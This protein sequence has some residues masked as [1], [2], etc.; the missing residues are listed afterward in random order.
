MARPTTWLRSP[1]TP[2]SERFH[3]Q[4][5]R[6]PGSSPRVKEPGS[7]N[8]GHAVLPCGSVLHGRDAEQAWFTSILAAGRDRTAQPSRPAPVKR[9]AVIEAATT[10]STTAQNGGHQ[11]VLST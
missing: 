10:M 8:A 4:R 3:P 1:A 6:S 11:R 9:A 5:E 7:C 2:L